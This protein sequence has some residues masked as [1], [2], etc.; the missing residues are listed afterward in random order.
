MN[1]NMGTWYEKPE[2]WEGLYIKILETMAWAQQDSRTTRQGMKGTQRL[3]THRRWSGEVQTC[4]ETADS[5][6]HNDTRIGRTF[7]MSNIPMLF[8]EMGFTF[9]FHYI[10]N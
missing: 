8:N 5:N 10:M 3:N 6:E 4:V 9:T 1:V 2:I 7:T